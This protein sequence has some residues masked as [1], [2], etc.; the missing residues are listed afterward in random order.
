[1]SIWLE[2]AVTWRDRPDQ[3]RPFEKRP[4]HGVLTCLQSSIC[5]CA[6]LNLVCAELCL[7]QRQTL[8]GLECPASTH[9]T[10]CTQ[11]Q[12]RG[13]ED[14][15]GIFCLTVVPATSIMRQGKSVPLHTT[16]VG[17][18]YNYNTHFLKILQETRKHIMAKIVQYPLKLCVQ[19]HKNQ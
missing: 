15:A 7:T 1:M 3:I 17:L 6:I 16:F 19:V 5:S 14:L 13:R 8:T 9:Q 11:D 18:V 2:R 12:Y 10:C 4:I